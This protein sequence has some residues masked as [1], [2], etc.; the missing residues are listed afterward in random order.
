MKKYAVSIESLLGERYVAS[1]PDFPGLIVRGKSKDEV[2]QEVRR[3]IGTRLLALGAPAH[4]V[5]LIEL[6]LF[7][8]G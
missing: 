4:G 6:E 7:H 8:H 2:L 1:V 5:Q 3:L